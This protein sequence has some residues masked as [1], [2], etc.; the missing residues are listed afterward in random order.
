MASGGL[1]PEVVDDSGYRL[2]G[3]DL[4]FLQISSDAFRSCVRRELPLGFSSITY[5]AFTSGIRAA[6]QDDGVD[7]EDIDVRL[8]GSSTCFFAGLHKVLPTTRNDIVDAFRGLRGRFPQLF[9]LDEIES[10]LGGQWPPP[11]TPL[12]RPFDSMH[13]LRID[14]VPSDYDLQISND[15]IVA[16]C[17]DLAA[18]AQITVTREVTRHNVYDFIRHDLVRSEFPRLTEF[19]SVMSDALGRYVTLAVFGSGG[20][21]DRSA[22]VGDLS[23]HFRASDWR[24]LV[25]RTARSVSQ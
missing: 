15:E 1:H 20:P 22:I 24:I 23:A 11:D 5:P 9:E 12:R 25:P 17:E 10:R 19:A 18:R 4:A 3:R 14:R 7:P 8:K 6:L 13:K 16:R 2:T 21:P